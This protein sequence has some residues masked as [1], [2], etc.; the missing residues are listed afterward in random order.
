MKLNVQKVKHNIGNVQQFNIQ[1]SAKAFQILSDNLYSNKIEAV[2]RELVCN[3]VDAHK[4]NNNH[5]PVQVILPTSLHP[6]FDVID[7]G[8][9]LSPE[10][11]P[12]SIQ[13]TSQAT[14]RIPTT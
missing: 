11:S 12:N 6:S 14:S 3:A 1:A 13:H 10:T 4:A 8:T 5:E 9:G 2:I 7:N